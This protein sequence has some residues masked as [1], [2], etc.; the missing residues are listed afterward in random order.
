MQTVVKQRSLCLTSFK[1]CIAWRFCLLA[2]PTSDVVCCR[3]SQSE[4]LVCLE[5]G[6]I[7]NHHIL[8]SYHPSLQPYRIW[9]R[10]LLLLVRSYRKKLSKMPPPTTVCR[11]FVARRFAK[12]NQLMGLLCLS[13]G[14]HSKSEFININLHLTRVTGTNWLFFVAWRSCSL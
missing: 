6:L 9:R 13:V 2:K 12:L 7:Q 3:P 1:Y 10:H 4:P 11:I 8:N 14:A 5:K